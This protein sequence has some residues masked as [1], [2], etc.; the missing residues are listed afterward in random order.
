MTCCLSSCQAPV[1]AFLRPAMWCFGMR[2]CH[3]S[4]EIWHIDCSPAEAVEKLVDAINKASQNTD[5]D[6]DIHEVD[7]TRH[8]VQ[9]YSYTK[10]QWLDVVEIQ[11]QPDKESGTRAIAR[12]FSS[13]I[14]PVCCPLAPIFN[15][16]LCWVPFSGNHFNDQRLEALRNSM[17]VPVQVVEQHP[18]CCAP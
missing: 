15:S 13:G 2:N 17:D 11:M 4:D 14:I 8:F 16:L 18:E 6:Y 3:K 9:M 5:Q 12:S 10:S 7:K 1:Q